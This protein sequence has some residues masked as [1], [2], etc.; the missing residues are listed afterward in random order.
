MTD[1]QTVW[2]PQPGPQSAFVTC[3]V[4]EIFFGGARG[5]GKTDAVLGEW[6]IHADEYGA[7]AIGLMVRRT[8]VELTETFERAR[9]LY[10]P[11]G[12]KFTTAPM[13]VVMPGG[14]RLTFAYL[15]RDADAEGYQGHSYCVAVGTRIRMADGSLRPIERIAAGEMV[16]TL[17][18]PRRVLATTAPYQA[19][20]V[21]ALV[22][23]ALGVVQGVQRHP[24]WHPVLTTAGLISSRTVRTRYSGERSLRA[25]PVHG[26]QAS[27]LRRA[28]GQANRGWFAWQEG[29]GT[30]CKASS[31]LRR[32]GA[33]LEALTVPVVLHAPHSQSKAEPSPA[34]L[35]APSGCRALGKSH[36]RL[37]GS[38]QG[39]KCSGQD[40]PPRLGHAEQA[41]D[42]G[43]LCL[44]NVRACDLSETRPETGFQAD[45]QP[46]FGSCDGRLLAAQENGLG[47]IPSQGDAENT[48][49]AS[50]LGALGTTQ[51]HSQPGQLSW[52]HP[53]SGEARHLAERV[54]FGTMEVRLIGDALV[55]D[56]TVE[57]ANH[58]ISETGLINKNTR[59]YVE[60]AGNFPNAAPIMKLHA[61]LRSGAGVPCGMRLTGN[62]GGPGHQ[63]VRARYIDP[64]PLGWRVLRD[65]TTGLDRIYIPSRVAD[66]AYLGDA[67]VAQ[68]KASGSPQLVK[69]WLEGDWS[70]IAGA[71]FPE[72]SLERHVVAARSLPDHWHRYRAMDWGSARPFS[73]GWYAVSDGELPQF[74]RG[75]LIR[76]R[77]WYGTTGEPN[78][79][80][81]L[82]AEEVADGIRERERDDPAP[83]GRLTGV[84]DPAMFSAD[85]GPSIAE[86]MLKRGVSFRPADNKRVARGGAMGGWDQLRARLKGEGAPGL[87]FFSNCTHAIRTLPALQHDAD[88]PE[89]VDTE[90]EDHAADEVRY[91]CMARPYVREAPVNPP[92]RFEY[93]AP[94]Q[95]V[96]LG[97]SISEL[98][99]RAERRRRSA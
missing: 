51:E 56:L 75:A 68:I 20:C 53:Y 37:L 17:E 48:R 89:D 74:P 99:K 27:G 4:Y 65:E 93:G 15:E 33:R 23:D 29:A 61:T 14:G 16:A 83:N 32:D 62:P 70:V 71:F 82:T 12:A 11:L 49:R 13:R 54:L 66:N 59:V 94:A 79:G 7:D 25:T 9:K 41:P 90:G 31:R 55:A 87:F 72:F 8:R 39:W 40:R 95:G 45:C 91:A 19:P 97:V 38:H 69:A 96:S 81:R 78:V 22:R 2:Q 98:I 85:G 50:P 21:E 52:V 76:Y 30:G 10:T 6:V 47:G 88:R 46:G 63:W 42:R 86:R 34:D 26:K 64:A 77:E 5:G 44:P 36:E 18:G 24:V 80:L 84:A 60:E 35:A 67:Y 57:D 1:L 28:R 58:Y 73:V 92:P 43:D 3:P